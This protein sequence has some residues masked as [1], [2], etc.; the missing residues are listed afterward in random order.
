MHTPPKWPR[1][2]TDTGDGV[3]G[4]SPVCRAQKHTPRKWP[5]Q[6]TGIGRRVP[7][8]VPDGSSEGRMQYAPTA[9]RKK[10]PFLP[11]YL[12]ASRREKEKRVEGRSPVCRGVL[13]TPHKWPRQG[14][15]A[16]DGVEGQS[17]LRRGVLNTPHKWP[18]QGTNAGRRVPSFV[19]DGSSEGRMQYA[20]TAY[21]K[22]RPFPP[23]YLG[24]SRREEEK[25]VE[26]RSPVCRGVLHTPLQMAPT[27]DRRRRWGRGAQP[28][29]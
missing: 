20:P 27:G 15:D 12:G 4:R 25:R 8:L 2:G 29:T 18:R 1:Q 10:R 7:S 26:G 23:I 14:T 9:Y 16:E 21:R 17:L 6:R 19:P 13:H 28:P 3:E 5:R 24:A 22:K 11:I